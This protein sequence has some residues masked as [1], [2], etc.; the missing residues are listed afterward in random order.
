MPVAS[1]ACR[2]PRISPYESITRKKPVTTRSLCTPCQV[3]TGH[4]PS[5][6]SHVGLGRMIASI[7]PSP[8][9][10]VTSP[11]IVRI[12]LRPRSGFMALMARVLVRI[13]IFFLL[14]AYYQQ[15][16]YELH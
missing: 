7:L 5:S 16:Y 14:Y 13:N 8:T 9:R 2:F 15:V 11:K 6:T 4:A 12:L 1:H 3:S 10:T